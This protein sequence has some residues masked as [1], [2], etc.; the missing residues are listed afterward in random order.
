MKVRCLFFHWADLCS[1]LKSIFGVHIWDIS[2][3]V[4]SVN[5][6]TNLLSKIPQTNGEVSEM[7]NQ[8]YKLEKKN[9]LFFLK[10]S[11]VYLGTSP[12][13][14]G[15]ISWPLKEAI[16]EAQ[17]F[18]QNFEKF[19]S[20]L[21]GALETSFFHQYASVIPF[22][23]ALDIQILDSQRWKTSEVIR[24]RQRLLKMKKIV[25]ITF[26]AKVWRTPN[27]KLKPSGH[28]V[29][30]SWKKSSGMRPGRHFFWR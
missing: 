3:S 16:L 14:I 19:G 2:W 4:H 10:T 23:K 27:L 30:D 15:K 8:S 25:S 6:S 5:P 21:L 29:G 17:T 24:G 7:W 9:H 20:K 12:D 28:F 13:T 18:S 11:L 22:W 1:I 26:F